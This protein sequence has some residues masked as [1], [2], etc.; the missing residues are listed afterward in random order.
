MPVPVVM[1]GGP[2]CE[3]EREVFEFVDDGMRKGPSA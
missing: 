2:R 3:T 1:A